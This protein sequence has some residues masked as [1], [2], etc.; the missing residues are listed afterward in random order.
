LARYRES[1]C[2][3][4][5]NEGV[6]LYL[7]GT[8]CD[9]PKCAIS[10]RSYGSGQHGNAR[11]KLSE[12]AI[13]LREKQKLRRTYGILEKPFRRNYETAVCLRG[14]TGTIMLQRLEARFDN[15][16]Y[17][18]GLVTSRATARQLIQHGHFLVNGSKVDIP[19][20]MIK[21]G[22]VITLRE[23]SVPLFKLM[24]DGRSPTPPH[25]MEL[26]TNKLVLVFKQE[27]E[28]ADLDQSVKELLITEYYSR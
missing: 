1:V 22:D 13:Q 16:V 2:K 24:L 12:F 20:Y 11:K 8:R 21:P 26:D 4:C 10:R 19:S 18:S 27:P 17:R 6:K 15:V 7:K 25:W 23:R 28:R 5:R 14:V 9:T 3:L